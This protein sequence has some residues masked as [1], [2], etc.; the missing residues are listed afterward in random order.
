MYKY[1]GVEMMH[2]G[3]SFLFTDNSRTNMVR[4]KY[5]NEIFKSCTDFS[6]IVAKSEGNMKLKCY[7]ANSL[8]V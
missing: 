7:N 8:E 1:M 4:S 6:D 3:N 2:S 5:L